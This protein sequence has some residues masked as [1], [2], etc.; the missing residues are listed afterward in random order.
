MIHLGID[1]HKSY[2]QIHAINDNGEVLFRGKLNNS[3][4][5]F[6][7]LKNELGNEEIHSVVEAS[8]TWV[9]YDLLEEIGF[10]PIVANPMKTK[11]IAEAQI[12]TDSIDAATLASLLKADIVPKVNVAPKDIRLIKNILRQRLWLV[13]MQTATKNRMHNI[14]DRNHLQADSKITDTFG[15]KGRRWI[16]ALCKDSKVPQSEKKLLEDSIIFL[17]QI[18]EQVKATNKLLKENL[19][20]MTKEID[21]CKSL[22]G[23]GEIFGPLIALEIWNINRFANESKLV[24]YA[25]LAS[26]TYSSGGKTYHGRLLPFC[27]KL[28]RYAYCEAAWSAIRSSR[29]FSEYYERLKKR[30]GSQK[31]IV[32]VAKKLCEISWH[33]LKEKRLYEERIYKRRDFKVINKN[34]VNKD[35]KVCRSR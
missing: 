3:M 23:I 10:N 29:F 25:G 24:G 22:P 34:K 14:L 5:E 12:K 16:E 6:I 20:V 18:V 13:K 26:T 19:N 35:L 33:C 21:I 32:A 15:T 4:E 8:R 17:D 31:A 7:N 11:A 30:V 9:V 27:N 1:H 2:S 28:L